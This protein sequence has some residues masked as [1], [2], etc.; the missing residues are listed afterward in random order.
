MICCS[1]KLYFCSHSA[2]SFFLTGTLT[3]VTCFT[4]KAPYNT[5][6]STDIK[7]RSQP[8]KVLIQK[9]RGKW[10]CLDLTPLKCIEKV[11]L[12]R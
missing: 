1:L 9:G 12:N 7:E 11:E 6:V 3:W 4:K 5:D 2:P 10:E 8:L